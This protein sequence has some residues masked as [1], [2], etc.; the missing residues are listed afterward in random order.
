[1]AANLT[2]QVREIAQVTTAVAK[3]DLSKKVTADVQG[4]IL[5]LKNT[6]NTMVDQLNSFASEVTRV[7]RE[8][9]TEGR[10]GGQ[11]VV[12]GV[13]GIWKEL[14]DNVNMMA[15][16]LTSQ[17]RAIAD[18]ATAVTQG[19]FTRY[20]VVEAYGEMNT[21]KSIIN[22]MIRTLQE[23]ILKESLANEANRAKSEFMANMSHEIRTPMNGIIGMTELALDTDMSPIQRDYLK[24]VHSSALSLLTIIN[25]VLDFSKIEAGKL[26]I[27]RIELP[28]R[29]T[30]GDTLKAL[31]LRSDEGGIELISNIDPSI[32]DRLIGDPIRL[33]QVITNL[34]GNAI[35][36]TN[37]G[38]VVL[39]VRT[40][41]F[42]TETIELSFEV[43]DTGI[44]I[45]EDKL[46]VIFEAFSQADGSI[47][48]KY[49]GT[50]LGLTISTR[51]VELMHGKLNAK[52]T[53]GGGSV[54]YFTAQF[55]L[56]KEQNIPDTSK[57]AGK[58]V[59]VIDDNFTCCQV[60]MESVRY[61]DMEALYTQS[62]EEGITLMQEQDAIGSP[63]DCILLDATMPG[64]NGFAVAQTMK[65]L[66]LMHPTPK[67]IMMLSTT[68]HRAVMEIYSHLNISHFMNKPVS[69][70][71][72]LDGLNKV[73]YQP[74][75]NLPNNTS[76]TQNKGGHDQ[77][78]DKRDDIHILLAEDNLINQK[79]AT[80][81]IETKFK[82]RVTVANNGVEAV[83]AAQRE[84]F[85]LIL[86]DVQMPEMGGFEATSM[87]RE[88]EA[89]LG[90]HTPIIALTAHAI[91]GYREKCLQ[92]GMDEYVSKPIKLD[93]LKKVFDMFLG[94]TKLE[95]NTGIEAISITAPDTKSEMIPPPINIPVKSSA[96]VFSPP[97]VSPNAPEDTEE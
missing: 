1:M 33:R 71:E 19:D 94:N 79:V 21:L 66:R 80:R 72:F 61:W 12:R 86:M 40:E 29:E 26:E 13:A 64:M 48:R 58:K 59:L 8:V 34:V 83:Q 97:S 32:P 89:G 70:A 77:A 76:D 52:S 55:G 37:I 78:N 23:T 87:I 60:L 88:F 84:R 36:F 50:G 9:G 7:A 92:G 45:P 22:E 74:L 10:L 4:E 5:E 68:T 3:G 90:I 27:E 57:L 73:L 2:N 85:S 65:T 67:I 96:L 11:A 44:G 30:L 18:V 25:D 14:T 28:L 35:K 69:R 91:S 15:A 47:T 43:S 82:Y 81:V 93:A 39:K 49:G 62:G 24:A 51:L 46:Q 56:D 6:I 75:I 38:E 63:F 42:N 16:N 53:M 54:F 95:Q 17:V 41:S 20:I 31:A